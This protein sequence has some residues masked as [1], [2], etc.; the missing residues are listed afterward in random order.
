MK[1]TIVSGILVAAAFVLTGC[2]GNTTSSAASNVVIATGDVPSW[3]MKATANYYLN[4]KK[5]P[6]AIDGY[7]GN[8]NELLFAQQSIVCPAKLTPPETCPT[9]TGY[10][11]SGW[12]TESACS[13]L[14]DFGNDTATTS[15]F[16]FAGWE[17]G[18]E[19]DYTEPKFNPVIPVDDTMNENFRLDGVLN[20]APTYGVCYLTSG[21]LNRLAN[22]PADVAFAL[23]YTIKSGTTISSSVYDPTAKTITV[24]SLNGGTAETDVIG[25]AQLSGNLQMSNTT[26]EAKAKAFETE[27]AN[28]E[29]YHVMLAG[30]S[31]IEFW[32]DYASCLDPIVAY[33]HGIGGT[34]SSDWDGYLL[35]RLVVPYC[36]KA[37]VYYVAVNDITGGAD[38]ASTV[39]NVS[40]LM[41]DTHSKLP[42]AHIFYVYVN[43]LGGYYLSYDDTIKAVNAGMKAFIEGKDWIEGVDAGAVLLKDNGVADLAYFRLDNLHMS[44]Y[45]YLL[46]GMEIKKALKAWMG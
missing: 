28:K 26:Y 20:V 24:T 8:T 31:S 15:V 19:G 13:T 2:G 14:W 37:V 41:N 23:N 17:L 40:K 22:S 39:Q 32:D 36:P 10:V 34:T 11:F 42:D 38:A 16:L 29:N 21:G 35:D 1:R 12:Y 27:G 46:W 18:G 9:R 44:S 43:V 30:S 6:F 4:Y 3:D 25:V 5:S 45:G 7:E 33:K